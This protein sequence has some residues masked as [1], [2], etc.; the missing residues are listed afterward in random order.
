[1]KIGI[2]GLPL[3]G[4]TSLFLTLVGDSF[5]KEEHLQEKSSYNIGNIKLEDPRLLHLAEVF[6]S[7]RKTF[8]E[9]TLMDL[10]LYEKKENKFFEHSIF[11]D[12]EALVGVIRC[13]DYPGLA[14]FDPLK[15]IETIE[16]EFILKDLE[17]VNK[18]IEKIE[19]DIKK[20]KKEEEKELKV[21]DRLRSTLEENRALREINLDKEEEKL[22]SG[23]KFLSQKPI[24]F[25]LNLDERMDLDTI[26]KIKKSLLKENY[27]FIL[28]SLRL[29]K[30]LE[31]LEEKERE[32]FLESL[33][34]KETLKRRFISA[35]LS[36]LNLVT[37]FT[38][39]G[40][41]AKAWLIK[42]NTPALKA[43]GKIHT[44][45]ERGFIKAEVI[46]YADFI[47]AGSSLNEA[48]KQGLVRLES[49]EYLVQDGDIIDFRFAV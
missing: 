11:R 15:E 7:K 36:F 32:T 18:R 28:A 4:K 33:G 17:V 13:F 25:V 38:V 39:K 26:E 41:E 23:F 5:R 47:K 45:M 44:D 14:P 46:N 48:R 21:L 6:G 37:F 10:I 35:S 31:S 9:I 40:E 27:P 3:S 43:A 12:A 2:V 8:S 19:Q 34:I 20:G 30:E 49:K 24:F 29:E 42:K 16:E 22:I 1:L